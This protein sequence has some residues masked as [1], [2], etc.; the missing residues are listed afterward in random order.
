[1]VHACRRI[2]A[3][4][5]VTCFAVSMPTAQEP[6]PQAPGTEFVGAVN[7]RNRN[8]KID[9]TIFF[10]SSVRRADVVIVIVNWGATQEML[11]DRSP[12]RRLA[13]SVAGA[14]LHVRITE[15]D[16][17]QGPRAEGSFWDAGLGAGEGLLALLNRLGDEASHPELATVPLVVFG[18]SA[19]GNF[20]F[21]FRRM[22]AR[23]GRWPCPVSLTE[24][25]AGDTNSRH[26]CLADRRR[27]GQPAASRGHPDAVEGGPR[28]GCPVDDCR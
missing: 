7:L 25:S 18:F 2:A 28:G 24:S 6:L 10:P 19:A 1:M 27:E 8:L 16:F 21:E 17:G 26:S 13:Q 5:I 14:L 12:W 22:E 20:G 4:V 15:M 11:F 3:G 23:P 9:G